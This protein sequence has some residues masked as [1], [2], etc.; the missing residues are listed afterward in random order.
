MLLIMAIVLGLVLFMIVYARYVNSCAYLTDKRIKVENYRAQIDEKVAK[1]NDEIKKLEID[2][3]IASHQ[4]K[5]LKYKV[6]KSKAK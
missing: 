2:I 1:I 6:N 4:L 3:D 5:D